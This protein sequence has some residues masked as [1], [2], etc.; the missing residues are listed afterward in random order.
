MQNPVARSISVQGK[1]DSFVAGAAASCHP[2]ERVTCQS[3]I[4]KTGSPVAS[5]PEMMKHG[6]TGAVRVDREY[7]TGIIVRAPK[8]R[9]AVECL[10]GTNQA[11][12]I[13]THGACWKIKHVAEA[14]AIGIDGVHRAKEVGACV[15]T[16]AIES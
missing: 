15:I 10:T 6:E 5:S 11:V 4:V 8:L 1:H 9:S 14:R 7:H 16:R 12:R 2:V 3:Q 13:L